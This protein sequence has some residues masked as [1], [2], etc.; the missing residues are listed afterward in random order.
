LLRGA[1][2]A[3]IAASLPLAIV[4]TMTR[5]VWVG[6]A[7]AVFAALFVIRDRPVRRVCMALIAVALAA[8]A[9]ACSFS[10][11]RGV[12]LERTSEAG[13]IE[14]RAAVYRA[15][16]DMFRERPLLGWGENQMAAEVA[17]RMPDYELDAYFA[18][19]SYLEILVEQGIVGL[20]FYVALIVGLFRL[21]RSPGSISNGCSAIPLLSVWPIALSVYLFNGLF[22]VMNY[23]FVNAL[24]FTMAGILASEQLQTTPHNRECAS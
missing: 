14:I 13:P 6:F 19:N 21:G 9:V 11:T 23:Q 22:V 3:L 8:V 17:D 1:A 24:V 2:A 4:A 18:H 12:L 16:W 5:A 10:E 15:S 7:A 20:A